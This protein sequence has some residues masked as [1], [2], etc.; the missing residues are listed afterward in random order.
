MLATSILAGHS[1]GIMETRR[2][3][4]LAAANGC[5]GASQALPTDQVLCPEAHLVNAADGRLAAPQGAPRGMAC[6]SSGASAQTRMCL[7]AANAVGGVL[8]GQDPSLCLP[9]ANAVGGVLFG[10][11]PSLIRCRKSRY[12]YGIRH[13]G[14]SDKDA[15]GKVGTS[16]GG[17]TDLD[18]LPHVGRG[19]DGT[20][21]CNPGK[22]EG[23]GIT[24]SWCWCWGGSV[25]GRQVG[26]ALL[27]AGPGVQ[28]RRMLA[29]KGLP[30]T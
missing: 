26:Q 27:T 7:P 6:H 25:L 24:Q 13:A 8:F 20:M 14:M 21:L 12:T 30:H 9:A 17:G 1:P 28:R 10:Q 19:R 16:V 5:L 4:Q 22:A 29:H 15:P 23:R 11:D 2:H 3:Q 18:T